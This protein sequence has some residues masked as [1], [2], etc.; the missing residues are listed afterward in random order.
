MRGDNAS[1]VTRKALFLA[2]T[3]RWI[4]PRDELDLPASM[5]ASMTPVQRQLAGVDVDDPMGCWMPD[6]APPPLVRSDIA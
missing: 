3:Y 5:V 4:R 1:D 2:Y 6:R